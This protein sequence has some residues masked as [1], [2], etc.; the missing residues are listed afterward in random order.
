MANKLKNLCFCWLGNLVT[1]KTWEY[2]WLNEG[3]TVYVERRIIEEVYDVPTSH[4]YAI[5]GLQVR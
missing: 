1:N 4:F 5:E 3:F 2:F